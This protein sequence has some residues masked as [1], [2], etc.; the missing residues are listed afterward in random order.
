[1]GWG[2]GSVN[3]EWRE[4]IL[5]VIRRRRLVM[6]AI[7]RPYEPKEQRR[8]LYD[9]MRRWWVSRLQGDAGSELYLIDIAALLRSVGTPWPE[10]TGEPMAFA[11][12][13]HEIASLCWNMSRCLYSYRQVSHR[14]ELILRILWSLQ[15]CDKLPEIRTGGK[16]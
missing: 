12:P 10:A 5:G 8:D 16:R 15:R 6:D 1:M 2:M 13:D 3:Q 4:T 14:T 7:P 11:C 9:L